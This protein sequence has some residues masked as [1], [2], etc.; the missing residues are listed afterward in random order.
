MWRIWGTLGL[1][2]TLVGSIYFA[3][4]QMIRANDLADQKRELEI[5]IIK[6]KAGQALTDQLRKANAILD[7]DQQSIREDLRDAQ[8]YDDPLPPDVLRV[9]ERLRP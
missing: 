8:G 2:L 9:L 1:V 4:M 7:K 3:R 6:I 5:R